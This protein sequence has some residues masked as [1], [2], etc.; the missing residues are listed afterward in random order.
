MHWMGIF[1]Y[2]LLFCSSF[3]LE[4]VLKRKFNLP[5]KRKYTKRFNAQQT[6]IE[7]LILVVFIIGALL[8]SITVEENGSQLPLNPI[9]IYLWIALFTLT[10]GGYRGYMVK[11]FAGHSK[12]HVMEFAFAVWCPIVI[13]IAFYA[14]VAFF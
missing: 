13:I 6:V 5:K 8:A 10:I 1:I 4:S 3:G 14:A 12:E 7:T 9:P 11:K 2:C